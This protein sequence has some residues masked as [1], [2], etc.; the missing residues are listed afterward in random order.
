MVCCG[1]TTSTSQYHKLNQ[2]VSHAG[3]SLGNITALDTQKPNQ[4]HF[5]QQTGLET[6]NRFTAGEHAA[7]RA[8]VFLKVPENK[9]KEKFSAA[10]QELYMEEMGK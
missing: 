1:T 9:T 7:C 8:T 6:K 10:Q 2:T 5:K 4:V 3:R